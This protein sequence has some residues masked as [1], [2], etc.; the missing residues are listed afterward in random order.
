MLAYD[1]ATHRFMRRL[2]AP[3]VTLLAS[4][5]PLPPPTTRSGG[6]RRRH[7]T[8]RVVARRAR[9][10]MAVVCAV[11]AEHVRA[12]RRCPGMCH[13]RVAGKYAALCWLIC[14][15]ALYGAVLLQQPTAGYKI[16]PTPAVI[17]RAASRSRMDS[18]AMLRERRGRRTVVR[19]RAVSRI[20]AG[21]RP[22]TMCESTVRFVHGK[23]LDVLPAHF[24]F[25]TL[26]W[27]CW[28][29]W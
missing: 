11:R 9:T 26:V 27:Q 22:R 29:T 19:H 2:V 1:L 15:L 10:H 20:A 16:E 25:L 12:A 24:A 14:L 8:A 17:P 4:L 18:G 23:I 21:G 13:G 6:S 5:S 28:L 7:S 3:C